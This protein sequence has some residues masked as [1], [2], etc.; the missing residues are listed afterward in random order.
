MSVD[1]HVTKS[2]IQTETTSLTSWKIG[3]RASMDRGQNVE[4]R[5]DTPYDRNTIVNFE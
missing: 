3:G 2:G 4:V 5:I 1:A